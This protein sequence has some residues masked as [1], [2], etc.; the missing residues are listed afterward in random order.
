MELL[1]RVG[2]RWV[3]YARGRTLFLPTLVHFVPRL[4]WPDKPKMAF[5]R[6]FGQLFRVV[7]VRDTETNIASSVPG[8]LYWNFD[9]PGIVLGMAPA[10]LNFFIPIG[11][12]LHK[13][14]I[15]IR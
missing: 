3:P 10:G 13:L 7:G 9:L 5:G 15:D 12:G 6:E 8:E 4:I 11:D 1:L 14:N 2:I